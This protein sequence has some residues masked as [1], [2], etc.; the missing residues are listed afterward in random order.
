MMLL[1]APAAK[2]DTF[3]ITFPTGADPGDGGTISTNGCAVCGNADFTGF[4]I[5]LLGFEFTPPG[6][7]VF[8]SGTPGTLFGNDNVDFV[9]SGGLPHLGLF[10]DGTFE[11]R[12]P[13][14]AENP[15][16]GTFLLAPAAGVPEPSSLILM[17]GVLLILGLAVRRHH[18]T[19]A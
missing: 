6:A 7:A 3:T 16:R 1:L 5:I 18:R 10:E 15:S 12:E 8:V 2:S 4:D 11:Y 19:A 9:Q 14:T 17:V 13:A